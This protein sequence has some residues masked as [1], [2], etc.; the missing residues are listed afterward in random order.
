MEQAEAETEGNEAGAERGEAGAEGSEVAASIQD[1]KG[2][3]PPWLKPG[4]GKPDAKDEE[5]ALEKAGKKMS[6]VRLDALKGS[7]VPLMNLIK[8][9]D[10]MGF[11]EMFTGNGWGPD[12][13]HVPPN[14]GAQ[15]PN[16][17]AQAPV[18]TPSAIPVGK[19]LEET[20]AA[21]VKPLADKVAEVAKQL[22]DAKGV[23]KT[24]EA[25]NTDTPQP[26]KKSFW[27]GVL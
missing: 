27:S 24:V 6:A 8:E 23:S 3:L 19:S 16:G 17:S 21:A 13:F 4:G 25:E 2:K 14:N 7:V 10:P 15:L 5:K 22:N 9:V 12:S 20:V 26:A 1:A 18:N 11:L